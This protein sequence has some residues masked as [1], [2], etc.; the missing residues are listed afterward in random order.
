MIRRKTTRGKNPSD[1]TIR[2]LWGKAA[3]ICEYRGCNEK[4][5]Y[6]ETTAYE[7][8][9]A[10]IAHIVASSPDGPRGDINRS[11]L[12]SDKI[13]NIMLLCD[14][15][16]RLIDIEDVQGHPED[17]LLEMKREHEKNIEKVCNYLNTEKT[18]I[19]NFVSPIKGNKVSISYIDTVKAILPQKQPF[20][21]YGIIIDIKSAY[22]IQSYEYWED[23]NRQLEYQFLTKVKAMYD[24][25]GNVCIS[26]FPLAPIPLI[27]EL[28][29][30]FGDKTNVDIYQKTR[31]PNTWCWQSSEL[32]NSFSVT[33]T[34]SQ[35]GKDVALVL[36]LTSTISDDRVTNII[37]PDAVYRIIAEQQ[38]VD[39][40]KSEKDLCEFW[41]KYQ[42]V[43]DEIFNKFGAGCKIH[44]FSAMPVSAAFEVGRRRMPGLHPPIT[45]YDDNDGFKPTITIGG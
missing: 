16:H 32:T 5:F 28:G 8:N 23:L 9:A 44:L 3:G 24:N 45:I 43:C 1:S 20:D 37:K 31:V 27:I 35:I 42:Q 17:L 13:E 29:V 10:Y 40:I 33:K 4:L 30:L 39:C 41:H 14:K 12:L 18:Q 19:L 21:Q 38:G 2:I 22:P 15:H 11:H 36:S 7:F 34:I 26:V 25:V 6:D